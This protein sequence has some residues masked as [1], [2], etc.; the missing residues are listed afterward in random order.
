M[1][2]SNNLSDQHKAGIC[3]ASRTTGDEQGTLIENK[4]TDNE[5]S[6]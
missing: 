2:R 6:L 1:K 3:G 4:F 5:L